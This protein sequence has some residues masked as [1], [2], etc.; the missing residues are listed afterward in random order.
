MF[1][2][3]EEIFGGFSGAL[4]PDSEEARE[5]AFRYYGLVKKM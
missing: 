3:F 1:D 2:E 5:H 4:N